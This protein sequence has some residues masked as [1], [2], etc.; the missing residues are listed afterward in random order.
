MSEI[1]NNLNIIVPLNWSTSNTTIK[2]LGVGG[3][4]CN[5]VNYMYRQ[6]IAGCSFI[7]CNTDAQALNACDVPSKI[8]LG[9]GLG[10]GT[11]PS[12]G[13]NAAIESQDAIREKILDG[14]TKMLFITAGMGGGTGTGA[15][16]VIAKMAKDAGILTVGVVTIPFEFEG[17]QKLS[18]AIDGIHE[19]EKNVDSLIIIKN[20]NLY[21]VYGDTLVHEAFPKTD[22]IL[23]KAVKSILEIIKEKGYINV[24]FKDIQN[25]MKNSGMALMG[26]GVGHGENRLDEAVEKAFKSPLLNDFDLRTARNVLLNITIGAN[27]E[28]ITMDELKVL[29]NKIADYTG[30]A[31]NFKYGLILNE[32]P[33]FKD[34]VKITAIATGFTSSTIL[35]PEICKSDI[36][37]I[38]RYY[39]YSPGEDDIQFKD[40]TTSFGSGHIG[41]NTE[42]KSKIKYDPENKPAMLGADEDEL[43]EIETIPAIRR[44]QK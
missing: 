36:I 30:D 40:T 22:E 31:N 9:E 33:E 13:R 14:N 17:R 42:N 6:N 4:G 28:S 43:K 24:D 5:A 44:I 11:D 15:I 41:F 32:D 21:A 25:M 38:D 3:G 8:Q 34:T 18:K 27:K 10:A 16:P 7:V 2:V 29:N 37:L 35:A 12:T 20:E 23:C 1:D 39:T 26:S 19:L